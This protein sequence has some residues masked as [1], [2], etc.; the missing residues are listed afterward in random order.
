VFTKLFHSHG[1]LIVASGHTRVKVTWLKSYLYNISF[2]V[3]NEVTI[4]QAS[5]V[6]IFD[7]MIEFGFNIGFKLLGYD[8]V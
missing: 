6:H 1:D 3:A 7:S 2:V 4:T 5:W 8:A